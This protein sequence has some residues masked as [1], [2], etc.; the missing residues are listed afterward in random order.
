[1]TFSFAASEV[2]GFAVLPL[3]GIRIVLNTDDFVPLAVAEEC[4][5]ETDSR[6]K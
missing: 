3:C 5:T 4:Q 6:R 2:F 1:M